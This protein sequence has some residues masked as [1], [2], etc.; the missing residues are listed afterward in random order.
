VFHKIY[1]LSISCFKFPS[2]WKLGEIIPVPKKPIP[3]VDNDLRPVTLTA[4]AAKCLERIM[5][6]KLG[7]YLNN[8]LDSLQFA[9]RPKRSTDDAINTFIHELLMH[10][11]QTGT[12]ARC[13]FLDYSSAFNTM[14]PHILIDKLSLYNVPARM[15]LWLMDFLTDRS[16]RVRSPLETSSLI[17]VNTGAPQGCVLS[18]F[19][20][21]IYQ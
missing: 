11:E 6:P 9:Y 19:L 8:H 5:L 21:V 2:I 4:I 20:F 15:K 10:L 13:T 3:K 1:N 7:T 12:Y 14:Q 17:K 16:Q 18:A